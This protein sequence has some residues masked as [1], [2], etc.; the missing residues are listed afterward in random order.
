MSIARALA[1][2]VG[3]RDAKGVGSGPTLADWPW[4]LDP[5]ASFLLGGGGATIEQAVGLP[6]WLSVIRRLAH[7]A[8]ITPLI[9]YRGAREDRQRDPKCW[10]Y[11]LL[12]KSPGDRRT[13]FN[14]TA[15]FAACFAATGNAYLRKVRVGA[16]RRARVSDLLILDPRHV[17][18]VRVG[19]EIKYRDQTGGASVLRSGEEI[20]HVRDLQFGDGGMDGDLEGVSPI[21]SLR[22]AVATG[23]HR[24]TWEQSYFQNDARPGIALKFPHEI[25]RDQAEEMLEFW[26]RHHRGSQNAG[27]AAAIGGGG[28]I[29]SIPPISL[30]DAQFV[31]SAR[32][33]LQTIAGLYGVP[34]SLCGDTSEG[35]PVGEDAQVQFSLFGLAPILTPLEQALSADPDLFP[36][37]EERFVEALTDAVVRPNTKTRN[38]AYRQQRQG[39]WKTANEIRQM[40]NLPPHPDGDALQVTPVGGGA[41]EPTQDPPTDTDPTDTDTPATGEEAP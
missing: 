31:E 35:G 20:I 21:G 13:P 1:R 34:P 6:A 16:G 9:V 37:G 5:P 3:V 25:D 10:Q 36:P 19:G 29:V 12:H 28:D 22:V 14:L 33:N 38:D 39:G 26:N 23:S 15:D 27:R 11:D 18:P 40:E 30:V 8:G 4:S 7:G 2:A 24:Q 32:L 41:N 17:T